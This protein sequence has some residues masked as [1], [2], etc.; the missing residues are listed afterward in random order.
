MFE[1]EG[2]SF[3]DYVLKQRLARAYCLLTDPRHADLRI[4]E[5]AFDVGFGDLSYF[6]RTFRRYYGDTPSGVRAIVRRSSHRQA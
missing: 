5:I 3:T 1:Q 6:N 2:T 4:T